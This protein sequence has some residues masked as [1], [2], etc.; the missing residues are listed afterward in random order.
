M[1]MLM[2]VPYHNPRDNV[3][4]FE[5]NKL[6]YAANNGAHLLVKK[7]IN[8]GIDIDAQDKN[9]WTAL[10]FAAQNSHF[11]VI[12][13]LLENKA[14]PNVTDKQG[15]SP[16]WTASMNAKGDYHGILSLLK[17]GANPNHE[18]IHGRSPIYIA[19]SLQQ[20]LIECFAPYI[21]KA[22]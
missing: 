17:I 13:L 21:N 18:N 7:L 16:L 19:K 3:D 1:N 6:H 4:E 9:G 15:N 11:D 22:S 5:R 2:R 10:H 20:G 12:D 14:N 8:E